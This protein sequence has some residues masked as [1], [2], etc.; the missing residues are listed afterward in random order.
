M[1]GFLR[2]EKR[3][4]LW[5]D[6]TPV[7]TL[8]KKLSRTLITRTIFLDTL[9]M[10]ERSMLEFVE[11]IRQTGTRLLFGHGHSLYFF[12]R[13]LKDRG[14]RDIKLDGIISMAEM[15][16]PEERSVVEDVFGNI[17]FDWYAC[18]EVGLIASECEERNGLHIAAEAVYVEIL[19]GE[20]GEPG[21]V[22]VTDLVNRGTPLIRYELGDLSTI[23]SGMC[24]CGRGLPRI[25]PVV[26]RT[27][28]ILRSPEGKRISGVSL[29][30]TALIHIPGFRQVQVVQEKLD[31]LTFNV[32][33]DHNFSDQSLKLLSEA[34]AKYFGKS[35]QHKVVFVEKI[36]LTGRGKFQVS[37]SKLEPDLPRQGPPFSGSP[38]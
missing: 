22:V 12:A 31:H 3:A 27:T 1:A 17:V 37:I 24:P 18:E 30:H 25:G 10:D 7:T 29:L 35:M 23:W 13:F 16:P 8:R 2:G 33:R 9:K 14:I 32:V 19:D 15:L 34:V 21:R 28:D 6:I 20:A 5:G 38:F 36:A 26:G 11:R 4:A